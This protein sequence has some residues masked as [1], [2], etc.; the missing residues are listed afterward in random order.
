MT[1]FFKCFFHS[2]P[3][4]NSHSQRTPPKQLHHRPPSSYINQTRLSLTFQAPNIQ[5]PNWHDSEAS[6]SNTKGEV[7]WDYSHLSFVSTFSSAGP[8]LQLHL[9]GT[10]PAFSHL[11]Q[12]LWT[13]ELPRWPNQCQL[14]NKVPSK[15]VTQTHAE[16]Y[17]SHGYHAKA[18]YHNTMCS[19]LNLSAR[20]PLPPHIVLA[21]GLILHENMKGKV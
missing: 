15:T 3:S 20:T 11:P 10:A 2:I 1:V 17:K 5:D 19:S 6:Q 18:I 8:K 12:R 4:Y 21:E 16:F 9:W 14:S 7:S 13:K